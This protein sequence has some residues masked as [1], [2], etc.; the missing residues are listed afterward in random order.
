MGISAKIWPI[1]DADIERCVAELSANT[2]V[3]DKHVNALFHRANDG[4]CERIWGA[5]PYHAAL[6]EVL[7]QNIGMVILDTSDPTFALGSRALRELLARRDADAIIRALV[8]PELPEVGGHHSGGIVDLLVRAV[9]AGR[10]VAFC[11]FED[12]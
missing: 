4:D 7:S 9:N 12:W 6:R 10:G 1:D 2:P 3:A 11:I 8:E 5:R